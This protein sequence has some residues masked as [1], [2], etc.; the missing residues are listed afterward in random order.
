MA[1]LPKC[2][3]LAIQ[4][5]KWEETTI[6]HYSHDLFGLTSQNIK[7]WYKKLI[8]ARQTLRKMTS[9]IKNIRYEEWRNAKNHYIRIGKYGSIAC[10]TNPKARSGP[11][12][13][14]IYPT[15]PGEPVRQA[16]NDHERKEESMLTHTAW[17]SNPPGLKNC[18]FLD[19][20]EDDAGSCGVHVQCNKSFIDQAQWDYLDGLL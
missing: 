7:E 20:I 1:K 10:M 2:E 15:R 17:I 4:L 19:I 13:S 3:H 5:K 12:V 14:K 9:I 18:H 8:N 16:I 6:L 11:V